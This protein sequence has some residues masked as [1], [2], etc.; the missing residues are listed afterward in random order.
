MKM[1]HPPKVKI[2]PRTTLT[3]ERDV[4]IHERGKNAS[5]FFFERREEK[6]VDFKVP[7]ALK[8]VQSQVL[9]FF[10]F[11]FLPKWKNQSSGDVDG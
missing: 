9:F 1:Y 6:V 4:I 10:F 8:I 7:Q 3:H 5:L 11:L 2:F